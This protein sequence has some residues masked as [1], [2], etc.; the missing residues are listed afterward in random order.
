MTHLKWV[1]CTVIETTNLGTSWDLIKDDGR[2]D[3]RIPWWEVWT[4]GTK[5]DGEETRGGRENLEKYISEQPR[6][7]R[8]G[9]VCYQNKEM[10]FD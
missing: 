2:A 1:R 5:T 9:D 10:K 4:K 6:A 8:N 3:L 7:Q